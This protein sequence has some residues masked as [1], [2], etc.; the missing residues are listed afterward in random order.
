MPALMGGIIGRKRHESANKSVMTLAPFRSSPRSRLPRGLLRVPDAQA[1]SV[2]PPEVHPYRRIFDWLRQNYGSGLL[3]TLREQHVRS[4]RSS[5]PWPRKYV[6]AYSPVSTAP[7]SAATCSPVSA[8][9][10]LC[11]SAISRLRCR[12]KYYYLAIWWHQRPSRP[13]MAL[14]LLPARPAEP[15]QPTRLEQALDRPRLAAAPLRLQLEILQPF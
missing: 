1:V 13:R 15:L 14:C 12:R 2:K 4:I 10:N 3:E 7:L 9:L 5:F 6:V 11:I 8:R